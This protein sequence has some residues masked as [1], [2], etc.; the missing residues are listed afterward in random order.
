MSKYSINDNFTVIIKREGYDISIIGDGIDIPDIS[1][2]VDD[3]L[4]ELIGTFKYR[5]DV[6]APVFSY[7]PKPS[8]IK[9]I[10]GE[11]QLI[12][13]KGNINR[14]FYPNFFNSNLII[15]NKVDEYT[16]SQHLITK[17]KSVTKN[18]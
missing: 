9:K 18:K 15:K 10:N 4:Q 3:I 13:E 14:L 1:Q 2:C 17:I 12:T 6:Y 8:T 16:F 5:Q 7:H 11:Y